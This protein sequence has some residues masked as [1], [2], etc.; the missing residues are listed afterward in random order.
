[1][2]R[3]ARG[4]LLS[5]ATTPHAAA[6]ALLAPADRLRAMVSASRTAIGRVVMAT[7]SR[8]AI[9]PAAGTVDRMA[10]VRSAMESVSRTVIG[11]AVM[12]SGSLSAIAAAPAGIAGR[13]VTVRNAMASGSRTTTASRTA[14]ALLRVASA[15]P[16][17]I[18]RVVMVIVGPSVAGR[19]VM[20]RGSRMAI[21]HVA[22]ENARR[23]E[24][25]ALRLVASGRR[26]ATGRVGMGSGNPTGI[27]PLETESV[28]RSRGDRS[29]TASGSLSASAR[30]VKTAL[31]GRRAL[32]RMCVTRA[33][34]VPRSL[35]MSPRARSIWEHARS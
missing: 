12:T 21:D 16:T 7:G 3:I 35:R 2:A 13:M 1:M 23:T 19:V 26:T 28:G 8:S 25:V 18:G 20:K 14:T 32:R 22:M 9:V 31:G 15:S 34:V 5:V 24:S 17:A 33:R 27:A 30:G 10:I 6:I 11:R 4:G 29:A